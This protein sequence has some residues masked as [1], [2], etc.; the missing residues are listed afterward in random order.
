MENIRAKK[1]ARIR[2][3]TVRETAANLLKKHPNYERMILANYGMKIVQMTEGGSIDFDPNGLK[4]VVHGEKLT[5]NDYID[6]Q[7]NALGKVHSSFQWCFFN[8][9]LGFKAQVEKTND[10]HICFQHLF[11]EGMFS[12]GEYVNYK[13][14]HVWMD[15][16]GFE[17]LYV[18]DCVE[19]FAEPYRYLKTRNGKQIDYAIRNPVD[20]KRIEKYKLPSGEEIMC[21]EL[22]LMLCETCYLS[23]HCNRAAN[24]DFSQNFR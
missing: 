20:I 6:A 14:Q 8:I 2:E 11:I 17:K 18:G 24:N 16:T 21:Q 3:K 15:L 12:D 10:K 4:E 5:Y 22:N 1:E 13:E 9:P 7:I 19:F 23:E